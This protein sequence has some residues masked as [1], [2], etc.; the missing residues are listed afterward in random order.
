MFDQNKEIISPKN[1]KKRKI[2]LTGAISHIPDK[3]KK[4]SSPITNSGGVAP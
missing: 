2:V 1:G 4:D 3:M